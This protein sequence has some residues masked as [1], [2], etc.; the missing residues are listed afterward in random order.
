MYYI[1][2]KNED[3]HHT[4]YCAL[5]H[6]IHLS[7]HILLDMLDRNYINVNN[8][9]IV[10]T[11]I[12]RKFLYSNIFRNIISYNDYEK[13]KIN[14]NLIIHLWPFNVSLVDMLDKYYINMF[15]KNSSYPIEDILY[16]NFS[17]KY[18]KY[19]KNIF[20]EPIQDYLLENEYFLIHHRTI[21]KKYSN[22]KLDVNYNITLKIINFLNNNFNKKIIIFCTDKNISFLDNILIVNNLSTYA[23]LMNN[24]KCICTISELS[25]AGELSQYC[26]DKLICHYE[27]SYGCQHVNDNLIKFQNFSNLHDNWN[28]HGC[29]DTN[30]KIIR[31]DVDGML[32]YIL[33]YFN[34]L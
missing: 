17:K 13:Q 33:N 25:G 31:K 8:D 26:H 27:N 18:M 32:N 4:G 1:L 20:Y 14:N 15:K 3:E 23:S 7:R 5:G 19:I 29:S 34:N 6:E 28:L 2:T 10:T 12:D 24:N 16:N 11:N 22:N 21:S 9:I 30:A